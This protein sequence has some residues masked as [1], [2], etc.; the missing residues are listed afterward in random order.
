MFEFDEKQ[1]EAVVAKGRQGLWGP[2]ARAVTAVENSPPWQV[3]VAPAPRPCHIIGVTGPPGAG[4]STLTGRLIE[5]CA[6]AGL[7]V[8][9]LAID[10]SS[11]LT[12]GAL[13]GDRLR[14]ETHLSGRPEVYVRSLASRGSHGAVAGATRNI[15]RLLEL[16]GLFDVVLIETV[17]A[18]Q[19]EV[20]IVEVADTVL[21]V[22]VPGLGDAVQTIKAGLMEV[23]DAFVVNMA[24]RPGARET[25]RHL[26]LAAGRAEA[27]YLTVAVDGDG[28]EKLRCGL[29]ERW[30]TLVTEGRLERLR[31]QKWGSDASLV[32]E[33]WVADTAAALAPQ[34]QD[35]MH[36][37][38]K[39]ILKEAAVRW[40]R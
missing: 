1:L 6:D 25:A 27:V 2:L 4:K 11:P 3:T 40:T 39:R 29:Q 9:V 24:D 38:V 30:Q 28:I 37:A 31:L 26:R 35:S 20:A 16:S 23:A 12:G 21:L 14:M 10:P 19:T 5:S 18:G 22:T 32:A 13:L 34:P 7:R 8:A 33:A 17:G 36:N 15:A